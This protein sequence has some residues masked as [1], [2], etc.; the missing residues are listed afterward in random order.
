MT[1]VTNMNGDGGT[2]A[3]MY[4]HAFSGSPITQYEFPGDPRDHRGDVYVF[5]VRAELT[6]VVSDHV[7]DGDREVIGWKIIDSKPARL[8][9]RADNQ[10]PNQTSIDDVPPPDD[11]LDSDIT[12][13]AEKPNDNPAEIFSDK[14]P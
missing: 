6:K 11:N 9:A 5:E 3:G 8:V 14:K 4:K 1:K 12:E 10:D 2:S 7:K 13:P